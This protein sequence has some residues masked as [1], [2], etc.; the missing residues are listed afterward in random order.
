MR[1]DWQPMAVVSDDRVFQCQRCFHKVSVAGMALAV[2]P[3]AA[4]KAMAREDAKAT[5]LPCKPPC[6]HT[7]TEEK[8]TATICAD[9]RHVLVDRSPGW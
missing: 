2:D 9:C 5:V 4:A 8:L 6:Q 7:R 3:D 1:H